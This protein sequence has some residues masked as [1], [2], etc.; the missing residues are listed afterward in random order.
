MPWYRP[1]LTRHEHVLCA[2]AANVTFS[3]RVVAGGRCSLVGVLCLGYL[4]LARGFLGKGVEKDGSVK[5]VAAVACTRVVFHRVCSL[6]PL[7]PGSL[8][9]ALLAFALA[10][11]HAREIPA[12]VPRRALG[13][14][15]PFGDVGVCLAAL[16][17]A[18][19]PRAA[20]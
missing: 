5:G 3:C 11:V 8:P 15:F 14:P 1:L 12:E 6:P 16:I 18:V 2:H 20:V 17:E 4:P 7:Y 10:L 9:G 19:A 13:L